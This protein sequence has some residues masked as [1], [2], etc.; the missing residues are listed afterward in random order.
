MRD[1]SSRSLGVKLL[2]FIYYGIKADHEEEVLEFLETI[3]P[4]YLEG[5]KQQCC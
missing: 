1:D 3:H 5:A 4:V 2:D